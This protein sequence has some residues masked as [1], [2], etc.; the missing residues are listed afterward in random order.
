MNEKENK[1]R[2][3]KRVAVRLF[4]LLVMLSLIMS[5]WAFPMA[6]YASYFYLPP[7]IS[8]ID[9]N[10]VKFNFE[11]SGSG[12]CYYVVTAYDTPNLEPAAIVATT[13]VSSTVLA[14]GIVSDTGGLVNSTFSIEASSFINGGHYKLQAVYKDGE[15]VSTVATKG[16]YKGGLVEG[17]QVTKSYT[18]G[19]LQ[20]F[21]TY[22]PGTV[23]SGI[24]NSTDPVISTYLLSAEYPIVQAYSATSGLQ[25]QALA[26]RK[27][28]LM[29]IGGSGTY[30]LYSLFIDADNVMHL[31]ADSTIP[32]SSEI[33]VKDN[34]LMGVYYDNG[35]YA[36]SMDDKIVLTFAYPIG[37]IGS[38]DN[39]ELNFDSQS[40]TYAGSDISLTNGSGDFTAVTAYMNRVV[41]LLS[42]TGVG[43][44][45]SAGIFDS[46][47]MRASVVNPSA[48]APKLSTSTLYADCAITNSDITGGDDSAPMLTMIN[49]DV[50]MTPADYSDDQFVLTFSAPVN[51][52]AAVSITADNNSDGA[53]V[54]PDVS[55]VEGTDYS[56]VGSDSAQISYQLTTA[57]AAKMATLVNPTFKIHIDNLTWGSTTIDSAVTTNFIHLDT[58]AGALTSIAVDQ[59]PVASFNTASTE[60]SNIPLSYAS[61]ELNQSGG[62]GAASSIDIGMTGELLPVEIHYFPNSS[63]G[64]VTVFYDSGYY[65]M[66]F[67]YFNVNSYTLQSILIDGVPMSGVSKFGTSFSQTV[68]SSVTSPTVSL[69]MDNPSLALNTDYTL[70]ESGSLPGSKVYTWTFPSASRS[71]TLTLNSQTTS[72]GG[73]S[74]RDTSTG[75]TT[76]TPTGGTTSTPTSPTTPPSTGTTAPSGQ[77]QTQADM[78]NKMNTANNALRQLGSAGAPPSPTEL[79]QLLRGMNGS[80]SSTQNANNLGAAMESLTQTV[81]I[82]NGILRN[83]GTTPTAPPNPELLASA[84]NEMTTLTQTFETKLDGLQSVESLQTAIQDYITALDTIKTESGLQTTALDQSVQDILNR[85]IAISGTVNVP[86]PSPNEPVGLSTISQALASQNKVLGTFES[87]G[88]T[89]FG[90]TGTRVLQRE[91]V[92]NIEAP[93]PTAG[94]T[95]PAPQVGLT[96]DP[97]AISALIGNH[98]G[99]LTI[100]NQGV[101]M[102]ITSG[103]FNAAAGLGVQMTFGP[104]QGPAGQPAVDFNLTQSNGAQLP[105]SQPVKLSFD[106]NQFGLGGVPSNQI[107]ISRLNE[108]T[109]A[110]EEVGGAVDEQSQV[111]SVFRGGLSQYT[112]MKSNK[113]LSVADN[114]WAKEEINAALNKGIIKTA[115]GF[116]PKDLMTRAEFAAWI[117]NAYGLKSSGKK[118][119]FKDVTKGS[120]YYEAVSAAYEAGLIGGKTA[121]TFAPSSVLTADEM[122]VIVGK[123]LKKFENK[124]ATEK[125]K[126][127]YLADLKASD[128]SKWAENDKAL[129]TELGIINAQELAK[130]KGNVTKEMAAATIMKF[131]RS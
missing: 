100:S 4:S 2:P 73:T 46:G 55:F 49:Y 64:M 113:T 60:Y 93:A 19:F 102:G 105:I 71:I 17:V 128:T 63:E 11:G 96:V 77:N 98:V 104:S 57:G 127:K 20:T 94:G 21:R 5:Q 51:T 25:N 118:L 112:V 69:V 83:S 120:P 56:V 66:Y 72:S 26:I 16:F 125:V 12:S 10:V 111:V 79:S 44:I 23:Y 91:V 88:S 75:G 13:A 89:Y 22:A 31:N 119:P 38:A 87:L 53:Y 45:N 24:F 7:Q 92:L 48:M 3:R 78:L 41:I 8:E 99:Q 52:P 62:A 6:S 126:S 115:A 43:K 54:T 76:S 42:E 90:D 97:N 39:F 131:Y 27:E 114:S 84:A 28:P 34:S 107:V 122:A 40:S 110:W 18:N 74:D 95:S 35:A 130:T 59:V 29:P 81:G 124:Q 103:N 85:A 109:G 9:G 70:S 117:T 86:N 47:V 14:N 68:S 58:N 30:K 15:A 32:Q 129:L 80:V 61:N 1:H 121:T 33:Y 123:T 101:G 36:N 37:N 82:L 50:G 65:Q 108:S 106:L 116:N 67:L